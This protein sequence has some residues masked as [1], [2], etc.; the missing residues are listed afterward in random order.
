MRPIR[1]SSSA[2][3]RSRRL[4]RNAA[5][6]E[7]GPLQ[8]GGFPAWAAWAFVHLF[9]LI[10][11]RN[12]SAVFLQWAWAYFSYAK[13]ARLISRPAGKRGILTPRTRKD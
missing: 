2:R 1:S 9:F 7:I 6:A 10:G 13:G 11:F 4:C 3:R 12:R 8:F 5:V